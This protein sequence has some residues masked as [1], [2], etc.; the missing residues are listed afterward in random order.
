MRI[1][2]TPHDI[3]FADQRH[4]RL[5][6]VVL[7]VGDVAL[8]AEVIRWLQPEAQTA[9]TVVIFGVEPVEDIWQ[10]SDA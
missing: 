6:E 9:G 4:D 8:A 3:V 5:E 2:R 7:L 1:I 10:P